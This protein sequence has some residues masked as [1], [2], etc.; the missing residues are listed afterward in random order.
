MDSWLHGESPMLLLQYDSVFKTI[1]S[2][3]A[4]GYFEEFIGRYLLG[5]P[6]GAIVTL[7]PEKGLSSRR[8]E[9][10]QMCIRDR[11]MP[12][13][14]RGREPSPFSCLQN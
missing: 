6:H 10:T 9:E 3:A 4:E 11:N 1:R 8:D 13:F 14:G 5:N 7:A 2:R 12:V